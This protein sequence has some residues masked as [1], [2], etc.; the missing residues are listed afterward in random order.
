MK[1]KNPCKAILKNANLHCN[2]AYIY[3]LISRI[4][5]LSLFLLE[6]HILCAFSKYWCKFSAFPQEKRALKQY[7]KKRGLFDRTPAAFFKIYVVVYCCLKVEKRWNFRFESVGGLVAWPIHQF[8]E[9]P[10]VT[11]K[12]ATHQSNSQKYNCIHCINPYIL[13]LYKEIKLSKQIHACNRPFN[14][15]K[16]Q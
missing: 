9:R 1:Q 12:L 3:I 6:K 11:Q 14:P 15:L 7:L 8:T 16:K 5:F 4:L 2:V 10:D 13:K